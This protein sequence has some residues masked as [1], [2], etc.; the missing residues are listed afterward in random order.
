MPVT[1]KLNQKEINRILT[2]TSGPV[3]KGL[4]IRGYK[5]QTQARKNLGGATGTGPKRVDTGLLR[6]SIAVQLR[7]GPKGLVVRIGTNV[8]YA[9]MVHNG[10]GIYGP[11]GQPIVP[12]TARYLRWQPKGATGFV[13]AKSVKGMKGNPFLV[14]ALPA[15]I[16]NKGKS[17]PG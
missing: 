12:K 5:V 17:S 6:A 4:L 9:P 11:K 16:L 8:Y 1:H 13:Y 3:A 15:A 10:T 14:A 2:S 7:R